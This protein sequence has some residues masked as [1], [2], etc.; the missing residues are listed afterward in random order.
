MARSFKFKNNNYLD[1]SSVIHNG[2]KLNE[3]LQN[4]VD[5]FYYV[6]VVGETKVNEYDPILLKERNYS[7]YFHID[8]S[9]IIVD[10]NCDVLIEGEIFLER[11]FDIDYL[12]ITIYQSRNGVDINSG[13]SIQ[14]GGHYYQTAHFSKY[15]FN[16]LKG[17]RFRIVLNNPNYSRSSYEIRGDYGNSRFTFQILK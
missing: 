1:S 6:Y 4:E 12:F 7:D 15:L 9:E 2:V 11:I 14:S 13:G 5:N 10:K 16:C 3:Y 8:G 17:D